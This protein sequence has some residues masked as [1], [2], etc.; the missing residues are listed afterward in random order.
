MSASKRRSWLEISSTA[1]LPRSVRVSLGSFSAM[2]V[3]SFQKYLW[4]IS[5]SCTSLSRRF[6]DAGNPH[7]QICE[8]LAAIQFV[9]HFVPTARI[10]IVSDRRNT[11]TAIAVH[12]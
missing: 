7:E 5:C 11:R 8:N 6:Q 1:S 4:L 10:E 9:K 3:F 2:V 12:E